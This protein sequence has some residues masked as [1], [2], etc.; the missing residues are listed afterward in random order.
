MASLDHPY[1]VRL[2]GICVTTPIMLVMEIASLGPLNKF[3][4]KHPNF[5]YMKIMS[6][7][8]QI[9]QGMEY[10]EKVRFVHRDLA[11]RNV[12]VV[13]E[14]NVKISDFGMSRAIAGNSEYYRAES[15]GR[16]P[17]KWYAPECIYYAKF[18]SKSDVWS[19]GVTAWEAFSYGAKPY[20]GLKGQEIMQMLEHNHRL[21]CPDKCPRPLFEILYRCW[22]WRPEDRPTFAELVS[23]IK[24]V[25]TMQSVAPVRPPRPTPVPRP[26][27][28]PY[29][30]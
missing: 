12:L 27:Q 11:A 17:L 19:Y 30:N 9:S 28:V 6:M 29:R 16:W 2:Y 15:A 25:Y 24:E 20:Q 3:L 4:R 7:V 13:D 1:I 23:S 22:S 21:D 18:D 26:A 8:L 10:L 14:D 5:H